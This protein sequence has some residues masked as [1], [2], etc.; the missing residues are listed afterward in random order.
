MLNP[1]ETPCHQ[2]KQ[3]SLA[4]STSKTELD[5]CMLYCLSNELVQDYECEKTEMN[6]KAF[7]YDVYRPRRNKDEQ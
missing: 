1:L 6:K 4:R 3:S 7:Q 2:C 5:L